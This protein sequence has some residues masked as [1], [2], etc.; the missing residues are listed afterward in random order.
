MILMQWI[1]GIVLQRSEQGLKTKFI[2][3]KFHIGVE[4]SAFADN[5]QY[6]ARDPAECQLHISDNNHAFGQRACPAL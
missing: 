1:S 2:K 4:G 6:V 5:L 3:V